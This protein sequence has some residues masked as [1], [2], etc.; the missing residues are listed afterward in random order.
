MR[1]LVVATLLAG[2][3]GT[4]DIDRDIE[5]GITI[6]QGLYGQL[7][8]VSDAGRVPPRI[9]ADASA[10]AFAAGTMTLD[11]GTTSDANGVYQLQLASGDYTVCTQG[12]TPADGIA[13]EGGCLS[14]T[15]G[16]GRV[17]RDWEATIG[18]GSW[19]TGGTCGN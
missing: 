6:T 7:T 16:A 4:N 15:L 18:G 19:C 9:Y 14:I 2:C 13:N 12:R 3:A 11:I 10:T 5:P 1:I 17:R 8:F